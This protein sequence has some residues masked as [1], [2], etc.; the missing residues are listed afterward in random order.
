MRSAGEDK[1]RT[2]AARER[3]L[4]VHGQ[5]QVADGAVLTKDLVQMGLGNVLGELLDDNLGAASQGALA[6]AAAE[7]T[8]PGAGAA[9]GAAAGATATTTTTAAVAAVA[10]A[11][12][13][14]RGRG[15]AA[16]G[17]GATA[18]RRGRARV[19]GMRGGRA[20]KAVARGRSRVHGGEARAGV[21]ADVGVCGEKKEW[22]R[23]RVAQMGYMHT[24]ATT[25]RQAMDG[26]AEGGGM[27][28]EQDKQM[29][30]GRRHKQ[31]LD[32]DCPALSE[33][34]RKKQAGR[35]KRAC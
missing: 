7:R 6:A 32:L 23:L 25:T 24:T 34:Q 12:A 15:R 14:R 30:F 19:S 18:H 17:D 16:T 29:G 27:G 8:S 21:V 26:E 9:A 4:A 10:A 13:T 33:R 11:I 1:R 35:S 5:I 22:C 20:A 31:S 28:G 2:G 3:T